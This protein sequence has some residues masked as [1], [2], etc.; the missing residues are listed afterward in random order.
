MT[1]KEVAQKINVSDKE[2]QLLCKNGYIDGARKEKN[3][4]VIPDNTSFI[5]DQK[6]IMYILWEII[7][8]ALNSHYSFSV[9]YID[10]LEKAKA[11]LLYMKK[12]GYINCYDEKETN[13]ENL[14]KSA[15]ITQRGIEFLREKS[16]NLKNKKIY[17]CENFS[18]LSIKNSFV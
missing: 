4:W 6:G 11:C 17:F 16:Q 15:K 10:T 7:N 18:L 5:A 13:L 1:T 3:K 8:I 14:L 2:I 9:K 12:Q